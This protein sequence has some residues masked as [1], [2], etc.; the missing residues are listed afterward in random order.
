MLQIATR[1]LRPPGILHVDGVPLEDRCRSTYEDTVCRRSVETLLETVTNSGVEDDL[2][3]TEK[4]LSRQLARITLLSGSL[5][6]AE[7]TLK[8]TQD[9]LPL[10]RARVTCSPKASQDT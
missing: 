9:S 7:K 10:V 3:D 1:L 6:A 4:S 2:Q 5:A 8:N